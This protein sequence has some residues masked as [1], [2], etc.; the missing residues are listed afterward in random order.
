MWMVFGVTIAYLIV[1]GII[2]LGWFS[3][4]APV[5]EQDDAIMVDVSVIVAVRNE[6]GEG[7]IA[8]RSACTVINRSVLLL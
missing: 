7:L 6:S 4:T 2:T 5:I 3:L 8:N 1:I